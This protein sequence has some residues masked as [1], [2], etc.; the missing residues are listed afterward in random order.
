MEKA[1]NQI[2]VAVLGALGKVGRE[3]ITGVSQDPSLSLIGAIDIQ[4]NED[5]LSLP[6]SKDTIPLADKL[7]DFLKMYHPQVIVDFSIAEAA[8]KAAKTAIAKGISLVIGTTGIQEKDLAE[9]GRLAETHNVGVIIAPNF[10][11]GAVL[12]MH[13]AKIS[14]RYFDSAEIIEM[15]HDQKVDA[16]SGTALATARGM[17]KSKGKPFLVPQTKKENIAGTRGGQVEGITI[18]SVRLPGFVA[19]EEVIFG[20]QGQSLSIRHD[21]INRECF[22]PGVILAVKEVVKIK[23]LVFGLDKLLHLGGDNEVI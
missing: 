12:L 17:A 2:T 1:I 22:V 5:H 23:G 16:P 3:I 21:T 7:D 14:A 18:H 9:I 20:G 13:L 8:V 19:S 11:L 10:A 4:A 15:H 6:N